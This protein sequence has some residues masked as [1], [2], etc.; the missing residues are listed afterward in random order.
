MFPGQGTPA[1]VVS[2]LSIRQDRFSTARSPTP[3]GTANR[4]RSSTLRLR[5]P[6][7]TSSGPG[8]SKAPTT[9]SRRRHMARW[10]SWAGG[11]RMAGT[12]RWGAWFTLSL[13]ACSLLPAL[14]AGALPRYSARYEQNCSL[15]HV[16]PSGGGMRSSYATQQLIPKEIA[17]SPA[18]PEAMGLL[19]AHLGKN[20][21]IGTDFRELF[22][23]ATANAAL[24]PP[25]G[26]FPMQG[27]VYLSF[28]LDPKY[29]LYYNRGLSTTY[30]VWGL[31]HVLPWDGYVKAGRFVPAYG[32]K[33]DDHTMFVRS[34]LGFTPP[35]IFD[36]G[37]EVGLSPKFGDLTFDLVNGSRGGTLDDDRRLAT[38]LN[39]SGRFKAGPLVA[40]AGLEGYSHPGLTEDLNTGGAFGYLSGWNVTWVGQGDFVR[41]DPAAAPAVTG[42]VTSHELSY[43]VRQG[44]ELLGTY[45]FFDPDRS[46]RT[47]AKSRWGGG[48]M[49]MPRAFLGPSAQF[50]H[51][52]IDPGPALSGRDFDEGLFQLHFLY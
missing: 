29:L 52:R 34:E 5:S 7:R 38:S 19:D 1:R 48:L 37:I 13:A 50:R 6:N 32:W 8:S 25:Q 12:T 51:T 42:V 40:Q 15:C 26:F 39:L 14:R 2:S 10:A 49:V 35:A 16:N 28:Q 9:I 21:S 20:V 44:V 41:R 31:A 24:A 45:D 27:D 18:T 33:F 43:L 30:E 23:A 17:M 4:C 46:L 47:G 11:A 22:I 36:G 3:V